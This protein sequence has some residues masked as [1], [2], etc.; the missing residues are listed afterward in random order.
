MSDNISDILRHCV[1]WYS[2][3]AETRICKVE[4]V[5]GI[6]KFHKNSIKFSP[7]IGANPGKI[8]EGYN[9][10]GVSLRD[11]GLMCLDIEGTPGSLENFMDILEKKSLRINDFL[12]ESTMGGGIHIYFRVP[13]G[14]KT[15]NMYARKHENIDFDVLFNGKSFSVPSKYV[16]K[17]YIFLNRSVFDLNS[18]MDIQE[19]PEE[20]YFLIK[21]GDK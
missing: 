8:P 20:L 6:R 9:F 18:I 11:S 2:L 4:K 16:D 10:L 19:F 21:E 17:S 5:M 7:K 15:K 14:I 12:T 3:G 13:K 1:K